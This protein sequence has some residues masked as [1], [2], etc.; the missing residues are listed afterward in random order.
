MAQTWCDLLF[1]H[2]AV[3]PA[4]LER[5]VPKELPLDLWEGRAWIGVTPFDIRSAHPR[6]LP[7]VPWL[8][9]FPELNTRTYVTLGGKPGIYFLSLDAARL[10]AVTAARRLYRLPYF[11]AEMDVARADGQVSYRST[12][13]SGDG[14][15]AAFRATYGRGQGELEGGEALARWLAERYCLYVKKEG[16]QVLRGEIHHP[17]WPLEPAWADIELNTMAEPFGLDLR[18]QPLLH[19][20]ARQDT[21][22]WPLRSAAQ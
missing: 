5:V 4:E 9:H 22:V 1:A 13:R 11:H 18:G 8:A 16:S 14:P 15:P 17:P 20:A 21:L 2:W 19:F 7:R 3:E 10:P 12:R 6:G